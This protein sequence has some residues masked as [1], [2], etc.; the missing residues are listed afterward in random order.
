[1]KHFLRAIVAVAGLAAV[2]SPLGAQAQMGPG[3]PTK[4]GVVTLTREEVPVTV[5]LAGQ[6]AARNQASIRPLV[7]GMVTEVLYDPGHRVTSGT[8]LF[9]IDPKTYEA[10]LAAAKATLQ[11][12]QAALPAAEAA[13]SRYEALVG[14]G[15]TQETLENARV[16]LAQSRAAIAQAEAEVQTAEINLD[17]TLITSP[18]DGIPDIA[19]VSVGD[20]VTAGQ[21]DAL[22]TVTSLDPIYVDLSEA[23]ARMLQLRARV[24]SG[25]MRIGDDLAVSLTL[26]NGQ[27]FSGTG[28]VSSIGSTVS[29]TTGTVNIRVQ[30]DNPR[31]LIMP[32]MFVS[33]T[34]TLGQSD[35]FLVPQLAATPNADGTLT[36]WTLGD[37][38][39]SREQRLTSIGSTHNAWIIGS[40]LEEGVVLLVDNIE[41][42]VA[43]TEIAPVAVTISAAGVISD[44]A[45]G[46][47]EGGN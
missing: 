37:D 41:N 6:V 17:R 22:T 26:E 36:V 24:E 27:V 9:R 35:A 34:L 28:K 19:A 45:T 13:V 40:G 1:M 42:M 3:G 46:S 25:E 16:T 4:A 20:L 31:R 38:N 47:T 8:P 5:T 39:R 15:A 11:S 21:S 10:A 12:A 29:T 33:A 14:T 23:S 43:G 2:V 44:A 7:D 18:I 30:F 32:G